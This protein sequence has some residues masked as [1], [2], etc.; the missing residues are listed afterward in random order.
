MKEVLTLLS[1]DSANKNVSFSEI[2]AE[3]FPN[4]SIKYAIAAVPTFLFFARQKLIDR[5]DGANASKLTQMVKTHSAKAETQATAAT[6]VIS[7][8]IESVKPSGDSSN[9]KQK[10][11]KLI[12]QQSIMLFM[13]GNA[14]KPQ[15][16][17]SRQAITILNQINVSYGTFDIFGDEK[18]RQALKAY[19]NWPTYPQLYVNGELIGGLDIMKEMMESNE[20]EEILKS[21]AAKEES[22]NKS[23]E[24]LE[25]RLKGLTTKAPLMIFMKGNR[26][27]PRCGFSRQLME[28]L[29]E[30]K[31]P[32]ET[33]D[34]L[35]DDEVRQGLKTFSNWPTY[36]QVYVKGELVGGLDI[37]KELKESGELI[38]ALQGE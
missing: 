10:L 20:L 22:E 7:A 6:P 19:S 30:T 1:N 12:N 23:T 32:F 11:E 35:S 29:F 13:K 16:G 15:C 2:E 17:F 3:S 26:N 25:Q 5:L 4:I 8:D 31:L 27:T 36:P 21:A 34:I 33:F 28:I 38:S 9:M 14:E 37:I 18:V 24:T